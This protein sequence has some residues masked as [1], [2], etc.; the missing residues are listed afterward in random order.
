M[1]L[2]LSK[3]KSVRAWRASLVEAAVS[4]RLRLRGLRLLACAGG[5]SDVFPGCHLSASLRRDGQASLVR[6][7]LTLS[8]CSLRARNRRRWRVEAL[9]EEC[10]DPTLCHTKCACVVHWA[11]ARRASAGMA[12]RREQWT[13]LFRQSTLWRPARNA[14]P[15]RVRN[16]A[17]SHR[18]S[19]TFRFMVTG[20][21]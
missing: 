16:R 6:I 5:T 4:Y 19:P 7:S 9:F 11:A 17:G 20:M 13:F 15:E 2:T 3:C 10:S 1:S 8:L 21:L 14:Q 12:R 18:H